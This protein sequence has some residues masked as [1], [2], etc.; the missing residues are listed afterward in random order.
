[1][2]FLYDTQLKL[3][4]KLVFSK[5]QEGL[6]GKLEMI[7]AGAAATPPRI[8]RVFWAAGIPV[9]EGYGL[10]ETS[11]VISFNQLFPQPEI[12][13][14]TVGL[15]IDGVEVKLADDG[16]ILV[17]GPNVM[18]GYYLKPELTAEVI[19]AEGWFHTG[20]IGEWIEGRFLKITD[21]KKE[22]FKTSAGKYVAPQAVEAKLKESFFVEQ[23]VVMGDGQKYA[24]AL[25]VPSFEAIKEFCRVENI[26]Y[27]SDE[28]IIKNEKVVAKLRAE[29]E[30]ENREL[31]PYERIKKYHLLSSP[32]SVENGELTP[33]LKPKRRIIQEKYKEQIAGLFD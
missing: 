17:K 28:E 4:R 25:I 1:M 29:I 2:G 23:A 3:A 9:C 24:A 13:I 22:I 33:T 18:K 14:G 12:R 27:T 21:R 30:N 26:T 32:L 8:A 19:D 5:W 15:V 6:G 10:T 7:V 20:D 11:P 31:A 16:E